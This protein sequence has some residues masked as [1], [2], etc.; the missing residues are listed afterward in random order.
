MVYARPKNT[1]YWAKQLLRNNI[2]KNGWMVPTEEGIR[3]KR[4]P[5]TDR[6]VHMFS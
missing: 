1:S 5:V 2:R 6:Y 4:W 3:Y